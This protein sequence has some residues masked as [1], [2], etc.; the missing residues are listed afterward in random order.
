MHWLDRLS[1]TLQKALSRYARH[2]WFKSLVDA[3]RRP[4]QALE[5]V[6]DGHALREA[7]EEQYEKFYAKHHRPGMDGRMSTHVSTAALC[8]ATYH[9]LAPYMPMEA[10]LE[11]IRENVGGNQPIAKFLVKWT[12]FMS[13]YS[14][15]QQRLRFLQMDRGESSG[16]GFES[17]LVLDDH[18]STLR[19][20]TCLY[21]TIFEAE[22][23]R[24]ILGCCCCQADRFWFEGQSKWRAGLKGPGKAEGGREC[25]WFVINN[26]RR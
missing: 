22:E 21:E 11:L 1:P 20:R 13:G 4:G 9:C 16:S 14:T 8:L 17:E 5:R 18:M 24:E 26:H 7:L 10:L 19:W 6:A 2:W 3:R 12:A 15:M 25:L 23:K